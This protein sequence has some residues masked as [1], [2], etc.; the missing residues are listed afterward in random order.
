VC[1]SGKPDYHAYHQT[2]TTPRVQRGGCLLQ[3]NVCAAVFYYQALRKSRVVSKGLACG[4]AGTPAMLLPCT[5]DVRSAHGSFKCFTARKCNRLASV[6][7]AG[8][9][10]PSC[11][12]E[13]E[14]VPFKRRWKSVE[15]RLVSTLCR[16]RFNASHNASQRLRQRL[17]SILSAF[18]GI[19]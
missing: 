13:S 12:Y 8:P 17:P 6:L 1:V 10:T 2:Y 5:R 14:N 18:Y 15:K 19:S 11:H 4:W 7:A 9:R 16:G 3:I